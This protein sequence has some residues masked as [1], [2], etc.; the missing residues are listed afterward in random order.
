[1]AEKKRVGFITSHPLYKTGFSTNIKTVLPS[2]Y[3][4]GKYELFHLCQSTS[5]SD[6]NLQRFP[7]HAE[8]ALKEGSFNAELFNRDPGYQRLVAYGNLAVENFIIENKLDC[9]IHIEDGWSTEPQY[10]LDNKTWW[11]HFK[12]NFLQWTTIDSLPPLDVFRRWG[13][14]CPNVW[15]WSSFGERAL[16]QENPEVYKDVKTVYGVLDQKEY[17]PISAYRKQEL[18]EKFKISNDTKVFI[19]LGRNQL[20]KLFP[21][22]IEAL[23]SFKKRNPKYKAKLLFHCSWSEPG[24]WPFEK[25]IKDFGLEKDDVLTTYC[26]QQCHTYEIKPYVGENQDCHSCHTE[27]SQITAGIASGITNET[28]SEIYGIADASLSIYTSGGF[29]YTNYQSLLCGLPLLCSSYSSGEDFVGNNSPVYELDGYHT[30]E[31]GTGFIKHTP[32]V[33]TIIKFFKTICEF[34]EDK[35]R[36]IG[37]KGRKWALE[38]FDTNKTIQELENFIDNCP[39]IE[40][41]YKISPPEEKHPDAQ[42]PEIADDAEWLVTLYKEILNMTV[43]LQDSGHIYWSTEMKKGLSRQEIETYFRQVAA[44]ENQ[45]NKK[46]NIADL[47]DPEIDK[48]KLAIMIPESVGDVF[49]ATSLLKSA[50]ETYPEYLIYFITKPQYFSLL[51]GNPYIDK[52]VPYS[53][54]MDNLMMMEG[55]GNHKGFVDICFPIHFG[56]QRLLSYLHNG[57]DRN[58]LSLEVKEKK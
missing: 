17:T 1:M 25:L 52:C 5:A 20:R 35:R 2:L 41:D 51:N 45:K 49:L 19:Q 42:I 58:S 4:L 9:L 33:N 29:E 30:F 24:G 57:K 3:K 26:C 47:F 13:A 22:A 14:E 16:K 10:Y 55:A 40:W 11:P 31:C 44:Q 7:W 18:R 15:F 48:P 34:P 50:R 12:N 46:V 28:L 23:A 53:E 32:N 39:E 27:K 43:D 37:L 36:E 8:G 21:F 54:D 6:I 56:T 38:K